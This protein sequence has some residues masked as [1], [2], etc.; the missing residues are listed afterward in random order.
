M[1]LVLQSRLLET[2]RQELGGT[3]SITATPDQEKFPRP[4]YTVRIDWTCDPP[5]TA[6]LVQRVLQ[7]IDLAK[8]VPLSP[9]QMAL[10][11][12]ALLREFDANRQNNGYLVDE[13]SGRYEDGDRADAATV[14]NMSERI[15]ALTAE[16]IQQAA[17]T[18]LNTGSYVKVTLMPESR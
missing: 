2:I 14:V 17:Q 8:T 10:L 16:A 18:Y 9:G 1:A 15:A 13:I 6:D 7:E 3:Y 12:G 5:R 11:R 4:A